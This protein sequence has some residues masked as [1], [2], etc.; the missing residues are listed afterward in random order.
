MNISKPPLASGWGKA[1]GG[2]FF[3][4]LLMCSFSTERMASFDNEP[5]NTP[6]KANCGGPW[7]GHCCSVCW[8]PLSESKVSRLMEDDESPEQSPEDEEGVVSPVENTS[9]EMSSSASGASS[10]SPR[11]LTKTKCGHLFHKRC[12]LEVKIRKPECPNCRCALTP[13]S[14]P[15]TVPAALSTQSLQPSS[16]RDA[17][18]HASIRARNAVKRSLEL[19]RLRREQDEMV[20]LRNS[21]PVAVSQ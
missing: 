4:I 18:V 6:V 11:S 7:A 13:V 20:A 2:R 16:M 10:G 14:N 3:A 15:Q 5:L 9:V 8:S 12:L 19:Q 17:V 1:L 21:V